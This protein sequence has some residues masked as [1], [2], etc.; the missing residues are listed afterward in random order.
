MS[1][2]ANKVILITG[3]SSG[4]GEAAAR[5]LAAGGAVVALVA[6]RKERLEKI[7]REITETGGK[8]SCYQVDVTKKQEI[9]NTVNAIVSR[10]GR[11]DVLIGNAGVMLSAPLAAR[12]VDEW[13]KMID[14][15]IKGILYG[16]AA[17]WPV[18]EKQQSGHFVN[19]AS[20]AGFKVAAPSGTVYSATKFAVRAISEGIRMESAGRF[21]STI[22]SPGF[23]ESEL[24]N[25]SAHDSTRHAIQAAY[26][27]FAIPAERV[28][29]AI[30]YALSQPEDTGINEIVIRPTTQEF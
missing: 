23:I 30:M 28:A 13:E 8:A 15:N 4:I 24:P 26:K 2:V 11:L 18:F 21:R 7:V 29:D 3:A 19:V 6:R 22:I 10:Y 5:R 16:I 20:V 12:Q 9:T 27:K 1:N 14:V 17:A 25:Y